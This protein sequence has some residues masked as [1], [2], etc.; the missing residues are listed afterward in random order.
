MTRVTFGVSAAPFAANMALRQNAVD[1]ITEFPMAVK[2]VFN[3]FYVDD[4][5]I[6]ADSVK[7]VIMLQK[8]LQDLFARE[9]FLLRKQNSDVALVIENL[10]P[11]LQDSQSI[12]SIT[13]SQSYTKTLGIQWN[14][15]L[16][17]FRL[18]INEL[19]QSNNPTKW[20]LVSDI[21]MTFDVWDG[22]L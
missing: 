21:A 4:G 18:T 11:E 16:A 12:L 9:G 10:P 22:S 5:L 7:E 19:P 17:L 1:H 8:Q 20:E 15:K 2:A 3:S 13:E 6:G 14:S